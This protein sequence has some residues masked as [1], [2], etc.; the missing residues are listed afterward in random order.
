MLGPIFCRDRRSRFGSVTFEGKQLSTVF[1]R[2]QAASLPRRSVP[3]RRCLVPP[4]LLT[5]ASLHPISCRGRRLDVPFSVGPILSSRLHLIRHATRATVSLRLGHISAL[6]VHRTVIHYRN[7]ASLP[8]RGRLQKSSAKHQNS[9]E[10]I[11]Y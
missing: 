4:L 5:T 3:R 8:S 9:A 10:L 11:F 2:S 6:T 7:A 1:L